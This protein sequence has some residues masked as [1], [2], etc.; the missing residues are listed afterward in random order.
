MFCSLPY[1]LI[2]FSS[3]DSTRDSATVS[4]QPTWHNWK[5]A[6]NF[7][8]RKMQNRKFTFLLSIFRVV[9]VIYSLLKKIKTTINKMQ[10]I[11]VNGVGSAHLSRRVI[12]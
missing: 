12:S 10:I 9:K 3:K 6:I 7:F 1:L 11:K 5:L 2:E 4:L 8:T